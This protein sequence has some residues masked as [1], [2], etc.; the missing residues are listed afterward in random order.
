MVTPEAA[1]FAKTGGLAD[2]LGALPT[3]LAAIGEE[4]AV[5]LPRYGSA[6]IRDAERI[7]DVMPITAGP[8]TYRVAIYEVI[9]R[10]V[11]YLFVDC[12]PLYGRSGIYGEHGIDYT[13]NY[14]RF[15]VLNLAAIGIAR[16][17]FRPDIFVSSRCLRASVN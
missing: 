11:H 5:V 8:H 14:L 7:W 15:S 16:D 17:I 13:D 10:G 3:A 12:P 9:E 2:V 4:I 1:P 6:T